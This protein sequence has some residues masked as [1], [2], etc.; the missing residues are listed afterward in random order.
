MWK[1]QKRWTILASVGL[2]HMFQV[3]QPDAA[4][5]GTEIPAVR[6]GGNGTGTQAI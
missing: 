1:S 3:L 2:W 5:Y 4:A 6:L